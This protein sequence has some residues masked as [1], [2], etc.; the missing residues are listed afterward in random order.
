MTKTRANHHTNEYTP[1]EV[2]HDIAIFWLRNAYDERTDDLSNYRLTP[3]ALRNARRQIAK[4]HNKLL[5]HSGLEGSPLP[6][7]AN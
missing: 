5:E 2:A 7:E 6:E 3:G 4:L 1:R